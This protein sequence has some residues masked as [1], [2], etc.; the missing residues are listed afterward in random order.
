MRRFF[1]TL[2]GLGRKDLGDALA[3]K[4]ISN[5]PSY[6][7]QQIYQSLYRMHL[8]SWEE[9]KLLPK[10]LIQRL[11]ASNFIIDRGRIVKYQESNDGTVKALIEVSTTAKAKDLVE[12]VL[13]P[14]GQR[15]TLC[16]S[17]QV[18]CGLACKFCH[19]GTL[20]FGGNLTV[21]GILAQ[22]TQMQGLAHGRS[23]TNIV[24]MGQGEPLANWSALR[25]AVKILTDESGG[26]GLGRQRVT[27][28]TSGLV[29]RI[30][31]VAEELGVRL[32]ISL[33]APTDELRSRLMPI[34]KTWPLEHLIEACR[35][36]VTASPS[37]R[38]RRITFEYV[39]LE[40]VNDDPDRFPVEL[41]ALLRGIP[42]VVNLIPF[43]PWKGSLFRS[44]SEATVQAFQQQ[45]LRLG[46][47]CTV[48]QNRGRDI[49]AACGQLKHENNEL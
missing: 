27:I 43:N 24:F 5:L 44:S 22:Y 23:I 40:G 14:D 41:A 29:P 2:F 12:A 4:G 9:S 15:T 30:P 37:K 31:K 3:A 25:E 20:G 32:A 17:S 26:M 47:D 18:G 36:F 34:A 38:T 48:R 46:M 33:H 19:T 6:R 45:L 16:V 42:S 39:M 1:S 21:Q 11:Q 7:I 13:I 10:D 35:R 8:G 49:M 28:S